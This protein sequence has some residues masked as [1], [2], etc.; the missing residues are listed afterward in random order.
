MTKASIGAAYE[1]MLIIRLK[2]LAQHFGGFPPR[3][4]GD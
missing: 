1:Q 3:L 2:I 4:I